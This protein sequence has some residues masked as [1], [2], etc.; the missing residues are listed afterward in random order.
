MSRPVRVLLL[1]MASVAVAAFAA[2]CGSERISVPRSD[3]T[4]AGAVLFSQRCSGC[5]TL[6]YA[7]THGS[8]SNPRTAVTINGPNFDMRCERPVSR[9]LY[10][11]EN[12][13]FSGAY[14]PQNI[15]VGQDASEVAQF[16][17][18]YAGRQAVRVPGQAV[19]ASKPVGTV[20]LAPSAAAAVLPSVSP[21]SAP[22]A[23]KAKPGA[24][25]PTGQGKRNAGGRPGG[26]G[27]GAT[28]PKAKGRAA[29]KS[30]GRGSRARTKTTRH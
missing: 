2:A 30:S 19:C 20:P 15:V 1:S 14:M 27:R 21:G 23:P 12:G 25:K 22:P 7:A 11:I 24:G 28:R 29:G 9:V 4:H 17:S 18:K 5:H 6:S 10:A 26:A 8:A 13:G 3:P 16:V